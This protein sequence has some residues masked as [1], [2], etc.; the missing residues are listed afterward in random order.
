M[1]WASPKT[2]G[3]SAEACFIG[4]EPASEVMP[5]RVRV[6]TRIRIR[7]ALIGLHP[8]SWTPDLPGF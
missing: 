4:A 1:A 2:D 5:V 6:V 7:C 3:L 8:I